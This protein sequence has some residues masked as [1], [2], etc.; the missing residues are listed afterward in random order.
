MKLNVKD[1]LKPT[2]ILFVICVIVSAA[3]AGTNLLTEDKIAEQ[4]ALKAEESRKLVI[5]MAAY[6][7][8]LE[9]YQYPPN[10]EGGTVYKAWY[11]REEDQSKW[12]IG[13]VFETSAKGYGGDV[14]VMTGITGI[15][16]SKGEISGVVILSHGET[17]G[18]GANATKEDFRGQYKQA[19][20]KNGIEVVKYQTPAEGQIEAMTGATITSTAV[21]NAVNQAMEQWREVMALRQMMAIT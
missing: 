6:F 5:P 7:E 18:L 1:I 2:A 14:K 4:A 9:E 20:P 15:H 11:V 17:P 3:L 16:S 21:T 10:W 13:Y 19:L 12:V 8:E